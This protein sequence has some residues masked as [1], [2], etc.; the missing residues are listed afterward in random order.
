M[1]NDDNSMNLFIPFLFK[2]NDVNKN[3]RLVSVHL[4]WNFIVWWSG[5]LF[6]FET[7]KNLRGIDT[8]L[9]LN[10]TQIIVWFSE[11]D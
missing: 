2:D 4:L 10:V 1:R 3:A 6:I 7:K 8:D 5:L 11:I 9:M